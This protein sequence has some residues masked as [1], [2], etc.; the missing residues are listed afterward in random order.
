MTFTETHP[1]APPRALLTRRAVVW[2]AD[3]LA[4]DDTTVNALAR[5]LDVD[6]HTLWNAL[7]VEAARRADDPARLTGV[8]A[9]GVDEHV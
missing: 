2:A 1:L 4:D 6:W 9:L 3:A 8:T 7:K 5:R